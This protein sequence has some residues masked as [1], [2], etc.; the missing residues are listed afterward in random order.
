MPYRELK[1]KLT[2]KGRYRTVTSTMP[3]IMLCYSFPPCLAG[4]HVER[5]HGGRTGQ[6]RAGLLCQLSGRQAEIAK[7]K[8]DL[9]FNIKGTVLRDFNNY[10]KGVSH[11]N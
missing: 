4:V 5:G 8:D 9:H 3:S 11:E 6:Q 1:F 7:S 2:I 10:L